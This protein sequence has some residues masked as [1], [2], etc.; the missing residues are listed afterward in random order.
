M[1]VKCRAQ[2]S[3]DCYNGKNISVYNK[4]NPT[5]EDGTWNG[6][7]VICDACYLLV[8]DFENRNH[9]PDWAL[10]EYK[11]NLA[12]IKGCNRTEL[13]ETIDAAQKAVDWARPGTPASK[14]AKACLKMA[15]KQLEER[16][17]KAAE[18]ER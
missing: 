15:Q 18:A 16:E 3:L 1:I 12:Y 5:Q 14:S 10:A 4:E 9:G 13:E 17:R 6:S 8:Q 7:S 2:V 11:A